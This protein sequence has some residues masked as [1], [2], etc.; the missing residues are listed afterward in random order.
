MW[1]KWVTVNYLG[2]RSFKRIN[3]IGYLGSLVGRIK[4]GWNFLV[5]DN[6]KYISPVSNPLYE[7]WH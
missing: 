3:E 7:S 5:K 1:D 2:H 4:G 6:M